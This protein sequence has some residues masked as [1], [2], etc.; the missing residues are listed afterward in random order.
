MWIITV[1]TFEMNEQLTPLMCTFKELWALQFTAWYSKDDGSELITFE[2]TPNIMQIGLLNVK[3]HDEIS[4]FPL[5]PH[6]TNVVSRVIG[7]EVMTWR[8]QG[9]SAGFSVLG[10]F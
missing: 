2:M 1:E 6:L 9:Q 3:G 5:I 10:N 8:S 4:S 7:Y